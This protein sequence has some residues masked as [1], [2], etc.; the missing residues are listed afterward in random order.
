[1][2]ANSLARKHVTCCRSHRHADEKSTILPRRDILRGMIFA[3]AAA[4]LPGGRMRA[5]TAPTAGI[6]D[7]HHH[8]GVPRWLAKQKEAK[9]QGWQTLQTWTPAKSLEAMDNAG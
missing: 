5:Q 1:M 7:F 6:V 4:F 3:S 8:F 9:T 2:P